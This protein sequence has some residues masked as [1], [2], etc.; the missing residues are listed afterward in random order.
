MKAHPPGNGEV[1]PVHE[2]QIDV[3]D[4]GEPGTMDT[5]RL[6]IPDIG[7]DSGTQTLEGGSIQ[8]NE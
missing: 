6:L 8:I 1:S 3:T 5:Y 4:Q 2:F 7:Y